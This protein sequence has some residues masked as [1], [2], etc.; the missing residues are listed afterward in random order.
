MYARAKPSSPGAEAKWDK[1]IGERRS[2]R[3]GASGRP[4][5]LPSNAVNSIRA[6]GPAIRSITSASGTRPAP[7]SVLPTPH[8][9]VIQVRQPAHRVVAALHIP[10]DRA[11]VQL[12]ELV[13]LKIRRGV[14]R[15][16]AT[17]LDNFTLDHP[18]VRTVRLAGAEWNGRPETDV[19]VQRLRVHPV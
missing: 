13:F 2:R 7:F 5:R 1:A 4:A 8:A 17:Q 10:V 15:L 11:V 16:V 19:D 6:S 14:E 18:I 3:T 12:P 9:F